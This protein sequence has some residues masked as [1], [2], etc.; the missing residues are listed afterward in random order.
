M[1]QGL[2]R[3]LSSVE[4]PLVRP[5]KDMNLRRLRALD[6]QSPSGVGGWSIL[7]GNARMCWLNLASDW[8]NVA[9][10]P[11]LGANLLSGLT[12][13]AVA[14][15]LN[16]ALAV[17]SGLPASVGLIAGAVGGFFAGIF[18]GSRFQVTGP[19]A[20]LNS[21]V[22]VIA[23]K[24]GALGVASAA[25]LVGIIQV[26]LAGLAAG[27]LVRYIHEAVLMGFTTGVGLTLLNSQ[28]PLLFD[29]GLPVYEMIFSLHHPTWLHDVS[30]QSVVCGLFVVLLILSFRSMPRFP[31]ALL[32]IG[33][34]TEMVFFLNWP[35]HKV[36]QIPPLSL[37]L[38]LPDLPPDKWFELARLA[39]PLGLLAAAESL[40]SARA[41]D[42][43]AGDQHNPNLE[44]FGQ[45]VA[46][47]LTGLLGGMP[48]S[49]VV[50]RSS[51]NVQ[52][53]AKN[54]L[55][56]IIHALI[57]L[58]FA[59]FL[60]EFLSRVPTAALAGLLCVI[61]FRLIEGSEFFHLL[62]TRRLLAGAFVSA[63]IGTVTGH[64]VPGIA[65]GLLLSWFSHVLDKR[66]NEADREV[67]K[68]H[69]PFE[70]EV[71]DTGQGM[72]YRVLERG[73]RWLHHLKQQASV[74]P[75]AYVHPNASVIGRVVLGKNVHIAAEA[76]VR[77]DEG[78]PFFIG[79]DTNVQ[80]GVV[81]HALKQKWV[82]VKGEAWAVYIG[83]QVS[84]AHQALVHGPCFIGDGTFVG[85][86]AVV[87]D[88]VVGKGCYIGI[89]AT[90]VGVEVPDGRYVPHGA[91][92][93]N[94]EKAAGLPRVNPAHRHFNEDV[95]EVNR[96]L[97][98]A[99]RE[100]SAADI[101]SQEKRIN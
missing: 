83:K 57:L 44:T 48:V 8:K 62:K 46:N 11:Q 77:A 25:I 76:S 84:L 32:G 63:C 78:T 101:Q 71:A 94:G 16:I 74:S 13:A 37:T 20:A 47:L 41:V 15:P 89:G 96:G 2:T 90:V 39:L 86:K 27:S 53:G 1:V 4:R 68:V 58:G 50:V 75:S 43:M 73:E 36:G 6:S 19:A 98:E 85:F 100:L 72:T 56:A 10:N 59:I 18:G 17:A 70:P 24:Y 12:V 38:L 60:S 87:H 54:R 42:R 82:Q 52:S 93:D 67:Q 97:A 26:L 23:A 92:I 95:V 34:M 51:V 45:G 22:I 30:W 64:I 66:G 40:L 79:D 80:D 55:S 88:S 49:G 35:V 21:M 7:V 9:N 61:G 33:L 3:K 28:L 91:V 65:G 99:Y 29:V 69:E 31:A 81:I 5:E 14:L